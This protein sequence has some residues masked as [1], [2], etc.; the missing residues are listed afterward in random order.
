LAQQG[1]D[2]A[3]IMG[4]TCPVIAPFSSSTPCP[5]GEVDAKFWT[6]SRWAARFVDNFLQVSHA[7][8]LACWIVIFVAFQVRKSLHASHQIEEY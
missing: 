7:D 5:S 2:A 8:R 6:V 3:A 1:L 4:D